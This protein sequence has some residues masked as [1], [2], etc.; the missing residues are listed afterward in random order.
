MITSFEILFIVL[1][2]TTP[3]YWV[4]GP[5]RRLA[6]DIILITTSIALLF[7]LSPAIVIVT[8]S[9]LFLV[10]LLWAAWR[11]GVSA[12]ILKR[13]SWLLFAPLAIVEVFPPR[14]FV[15]FVFGEAASTAPGI[16]NWAYLGISYT[17]I[18]CFIIFRESLA[19]KIFPTRPAIV[20]LTFFGSF[21]AGPIA[22]AQPFLHEN[23]LRRM[24]FSILCVALS[25]I[26]WG[27]AL[28]LVATPTL[29]AL[30]IAKWVGNGSSLAWLDLYRDFFALYFDFTG[31]T[32]IAIG[33]ALLFGI[34]LPENFRD[35]LLARSLQEFWQRWHLTLG[36]FIS[37]YL[38]QP[39]VRHT[40][41]PKLAIL[42][43]FILIGLWHD[44]SSTYL[45]WGIGHGTALAL[46][47]EFAKRR[48]LGSSTLFLLRVF[49]RPL[50]ITY[51]SLLSALANTGDLSRAM[52]LLENLA[53]FE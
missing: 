42:T 7:A 53:G 33:C 37:R 46:Q 29:V 6:G 36:A 13:L 23:R 16:V 48:H 35:P 9:C 39:L 24:R 45:L 51:V 44:I 22:G 18:R 12:K 49:Q 8:I 27:S 52:I 11:L 2:V 47:M 1:G 25:R 15:E 50:T 20:A 21:P 38:F 19:H 26:G 28:L 34:E 4:A 43:S 5:E 41:R 40:G 14:S 3:L 31:Y 17:T 10:L 32:S 30:D